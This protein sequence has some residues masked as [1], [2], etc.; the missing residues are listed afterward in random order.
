MRCPLAQLHSLYPL[1]YLTYYFARFYAPGGSNLYYLR[2][3][4]LWYDRLQLDIVCNGA[5]HSIRRRP[6]KTRESARPRS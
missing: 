1:L 6:S 5:P 4:D 2:T 3:I